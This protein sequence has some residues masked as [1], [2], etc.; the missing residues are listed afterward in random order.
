[1]LALAG[2]DFVITRNLIVAVVP[3]IAL[4]AAA[5]SRMRAGPALVG[6]ICACGVAAFI[7]VE[8]DPAYQRDDWRGVAS[9]IGPLAGT[10][11]TAV[12]VEPASG[13]L[14]L[15]VYAPLRGIPSNA[16]IFTRAIDVVALGR[17]APVPATPA[18]AAGF[19]ATVEHH[20]DFTL[21]R[22]VAAQTEEVTFG[23]LVQL[24]IGA[25]SP[26]AVL[27]SPPYP[28]NVLPS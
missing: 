5:A 10:T 8:A 17:D 12:V 27:V 13:Q 25:T 21:V 11:T 7:G 4:A 15:K 23:E 18:P 26:P 2:G 19:T 20:A 24:A 6:V 3:L 22:Y 1:M 14:P 28:F 16:A 9:A